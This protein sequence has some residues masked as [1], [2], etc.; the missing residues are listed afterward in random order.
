MQDLLKFWF[1]NFKSIKFIKIF[2]E[3]F[4]INSI[5]FTEFF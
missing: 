4:Q 5:N 2:K 3:L 1:F